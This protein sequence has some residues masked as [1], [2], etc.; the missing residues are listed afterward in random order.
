MIKRVLA[1]V[2][3]SALSTTYFMDEQK[4]PKNTERHAICILYPNNSNVRGIASFSQ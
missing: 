2:C 1:A 4:Q 3:T